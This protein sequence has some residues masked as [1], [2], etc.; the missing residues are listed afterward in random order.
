MK[1][2]ILFLLFSINLQS[3]ANS[4]PYDPLAKV[5]LENPQN[6]NIPT[7][8]NHSIKEPEECLIP[9]TCP[10]CEVIEEWPIDFDGDDLAEKA[11]KRQCGL[12]SLDEERHQEVII[13]LSSTGEPIIYKTTF[14][15]CH[16]EKETK[17]T[18]FERV[19]FNKDNL[20]ELV[21]VEHDLKSDNDQI[22]ILG[23]NKD[24]NAITEIPLL[25][26][27]TDLKE[28]FGQDENKEKTKTKFLRR[29]KLYGFV[30]DYLSSSNRT[31]RIYYYQDAADRA[32]YP[33]KISEVNKPN[34]SASKIFTAIQAP[35][36]K[37]V[38]SVEIIE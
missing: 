36:I 23:F 17:F 35:I 31:F 27:H 11:Q 18:H 21:L 2:L 20:D 5:N 6:T 12:S 38:N 26:Y 14:S 4:W 32:F 22:S 19:D 25:E 3:L 9:A 1:L 28:R 34:V 8:P 24:K 29:N 33:L 7:S 16:P 30:L 37:N 10:I 15:N 13:I